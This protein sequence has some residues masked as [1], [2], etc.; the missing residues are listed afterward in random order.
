ML[1]FAVLHAG[2]ALLKPVTWQSLVAGLSIDLR[3]LLYF[4][5]VYV[6]LALYP[7]YK[8]QFI[9]IGIAGA[10]VVLVGVVAFGMKYGR[11]VR[12]QRRRWLHA[13]L[14]VGSIIALWVSYS[15]SAWIGAAVG[16]L[17]AVGARYGKHLDAK[18]WSIVA[19]I[20]A[21][22]VV[23]SL[24]LKDSSFFRTVILHDSPTTGATV[25]SNTAHAA[26]LGDGFNRMLA[27]PLGTGVGSTGSASLMGGEPLIIENHYLFVAHEVGWLG[28]GLFISIMIVTLRR[29]WARRADWLALTLFGSGIGLSV[30]GLLL[31]VWVD[32]TV[33]IIWWGMAAV[34]LA[35]GET[36]GTT[37]KKA[38]RTA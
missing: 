38:T 35:K 5:L 37:N 6:F 16:I 30:V 10:L 36:H 4:C 11:T 2:I 3:Y 27:Q 13:F 21:L 28:L 1:A 26:S 8:Q 9:T 22:L 18:K 20:T 19:V 24:L 15:R 25:D 17:T 7:R 14:A 33:S 34:V 23:G 32:D 29:L 12:D 31:P